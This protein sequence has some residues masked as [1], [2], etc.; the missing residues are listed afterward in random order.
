MGSII[1]GAIQGELGRQ[2]VGSWTTGSRDLVL[3]S[4]R[5]A[6]TRAQDR[7]RPDAAGLMVG[8]AT[9]IS[10]TSKPPR[11]ASPRLHQQDPANPSPC[12]GI[13]TEAPADRSARRAPSGL[14]DRSRDHAPR[15]GRAHGLDAV[16]GG[17]VSPCARDRCARGGDRRRVAGWSEPLLLLCPHRRTRPA[18]QFFRVRARTRQGHG[19]RQRQDRPR[20]HAER[21]G[22]RQ[23]R[24]F[25]TGTTRAREPSRG[26]QQTS[27]ATNKDVPTT[28]SIAAG[29]TQERAKAC[30]D[31]RRYRRRGRARSKVGA[32]A[33]SLVELSSWRGRATSLESGAG[34]HRAGRRTHQ[35]GC[36]LG[37]PLDRRNQQRPD[38]DAELIARLCSHT[39]N[40]RS[41]KP[42]RLVREQ[43]ARADGGG[44]PHPHHGCSQASPS[45]GGSR[46]QER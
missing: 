34:R 15:S 22:S 12:A 36:P 9:E 3:Q 45:R 5:S 40:D 19:L 14:F 46:R 21:A 32:F 25:R 43:R 11:P 20:G 24:D 30:P 31:P 42:H 33:R 10:T 7:G 18:S 29:S 41:C 16:G 26:T 4:G 13:R 27:A 8:S 2:R 17:L 38:L 6:R 28:N 37:Q 44:T 1:P 39:A 35:V 23:A